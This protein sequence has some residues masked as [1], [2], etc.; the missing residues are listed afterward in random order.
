MAWGQRDVL[1]MIMN[2]RVKPFD[3]GRGHSR[4]T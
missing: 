1:S 4:S 3:G 2:R